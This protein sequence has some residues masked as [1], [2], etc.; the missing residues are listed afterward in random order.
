MVSTPSRRRPWVALAAT[1]AVVP[2][3]LAG[4]SSS[5]DSGSSDTTSTADS[6]DLGTANGATGAP[7]T[8]GYISDGKSE[9]IDQTDELK[10]AQAAIDYA[11]A[12]LG[13]VG[14]HK[15]ELK[16]C[17]ALATPAQTTDCANQ[18]VQAGVSAVLAGTLAQSDSAVGVLSA[19]QIPLMFQ[20]AASA[21]VLSSPGVFTLT[22]PLSY[23]G[24]AAGYAKENSLT[25]AVQVVIDVPGAAGPAKTLGTKVFQNAGSTLSVLAV[26]AGTADMTPQIQSSQDG[27]PDQYNILGNAAFC[28]SALKSIE[29]LGVT[30]DV[31]VADVCLGSGGSSIA[32]G[33]EG[34]HVITTL[35]LADSDP[36]F[37]AFSAAIDQYGNGVKV[38]PVS[39]VGYSVTLG[40]V[41]ALNAADITD[42]TP[43]GVLAAI[44]AA[45]ATP[46]P[47]Q[48]GGTFKC[49]GSAMTAISP[50]I[51]S[52]TGIIAESD[53]DGKLSN[54]E[55]V[56]G[57]GIYN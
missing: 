7:I 47:L 37:A 17:E 2:V 18:M 40:A 24:T 54:Y 15:I 23:F 10:G 26:P 28:T 3:L 57:A 45:P 19:A 46:F 43:A 51:C 41:R 49:D 52:S 25:K 12:Y 20:Q 30:A 36:D 33:Y 53:K 39:A 13:G 9:A 38:G 5:D 6:A 8:F 44:K 1:A 55:V 21:S 29:T 22:N 34:L 14:G 4:C 27:D 48:G 16:T 11:N 31:T 32:G 42:T 35:Q 50:N 56:D